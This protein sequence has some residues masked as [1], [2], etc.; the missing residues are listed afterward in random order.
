[1]GYH[2]PSLPTDFAEQESD[3][4]ICFFR[5]RINLCRIFPRKIQDKFR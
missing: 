3:Q 5:I 2:G 4:G 1:M